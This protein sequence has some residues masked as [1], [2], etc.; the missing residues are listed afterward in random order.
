VACCTVGVLA[1]LNSGASRALSL[2]S[3]NHCSRSQ[4]HSFLP[5]RDIKTTQEPAV[6]SQHCH[7]IHVHVTNRV[8]HKP[9]GQY[10]HTGECTTHSFKQS[11]AHLLRC[12]WWVLSAP[13]A[14]HQQHNQQ[15]PHHS[16]L[17]LLHPQHCCCPV[18]SQQLPALRP[19]LLPA[20]RSRRQ[21]TRDTALQQGGVVKNNQS[22]FR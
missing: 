11:Y 10:M 9:H 22:L 8:V 18:F 1:S 14:Q 19:C 7:T 20:V 13:S 6:L 5:S 3:V 15:T 16:L 17:L 4:R 2:D 12:C 21:G